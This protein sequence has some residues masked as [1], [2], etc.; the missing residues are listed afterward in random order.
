MRIKAY[1]VMAIAAFIAFSCSDGRK[2]GQMTEIEIDFKKK[3]NLKIDDK[4]IV[5]LETSDS[6]LLF[7][8]CNV[9][10]VDSFYVIHSRNFL[11]VF[12][13]EG[14]YIR[15]IGGLGNSRNEYKSIANFFVED[16]VVTLYDFSSKSLISYD[17]NGVYK[18]R[19]KVV[20]SGGTNAIVPN[21]LYKSDGGYV[22][23]NTFGGSDRTVTCLSR[24]DSLMTEYTP[25]VGRDLENGFFL[26]DDVCM[27]DDK[28]LY[29]QPLCDT[30]FVAEGNEVFPL[31]HFNLGKYSMPNE[32]ACKNVYER[33]D[34]SNK[35][36]K[37]GKPFAG[38]LRYYSVCDK[39]IYFV[40][41]A[42]GYE[43]MLCS[44]NTEN[45]D[46][47]VYQLELPKED[48]QVQPFL[49]ILGDELVMYAIDKT[50]ATENP[51]L[52]TLEI[53]KVR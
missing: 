23:V 43:I 33:I 6:S 45:N 12:D 47:R 31:Y 28:I 37:E 50:K 41:V 20:G 44:L 22:C 11:R 34:Y 13:K 3:E 5:S 17:V 42:P 36:Y 9:E 49:K 29:W 52:I 1:I 53:E 26:P 21:H 19:R 46:V 10:T 51:Y 32:V 24:I 15:N 38:M 4:Q 35:M 40:C 27:Y 25:L 16:D 30:L 8:I 18:G 39:L 14:N 2:H 7:D 48:L